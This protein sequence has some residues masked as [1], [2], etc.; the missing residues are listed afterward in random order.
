MLCSDQ[1]FDIAQVI[2]FFRSKPGELI[3]YYELEEG[4]RSSSRG[5]VEVCPETHRITRFL[6]KPEEERTTSRLASV[7]FYCIRGETLSYMSDFLS[8]QPQASER[9]FGLFWVRR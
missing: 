2:R 1:N 8:L 9:T 7:V 5:I 6:E 4:E 3:I